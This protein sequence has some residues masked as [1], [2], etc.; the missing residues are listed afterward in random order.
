MLFALAENGELPRFFGRIHP[1]FRTPANA[2][3]FTSA[4]A[5]VLALTGSFVALAAVSAVARLVTYVGACAATL[6]LRAPRYEQA[7][8]PASFVIP[9]GPVVPVLAV[10]ISMAIL[11]GASWAQLVGG[12]LALLGGAA[13]F[14]LNQVLHPHP[15]RARP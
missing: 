15:G 3:V 8:Q 5:L 12:A 1:T 2:I 13:L 9:L 7:V 14:W 6:A 10:A 11:A 4:V